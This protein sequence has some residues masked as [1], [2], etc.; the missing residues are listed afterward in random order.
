MKNTIILY[1]LL[2]ISSCAEK[3]NNVIIK[4]DIPNLPNGVLY[5]YKDISTNIVDSTV[6]KD[7]KF[8]I[9]YNSKT[10]EVSY[11]GIDHIDKKGILRAFYFPTNAKYKNSGYDSQFFLSDSVVLI[12]GDFKD[13]KLAGIA[14]G[15]MKI[16]TTPKI[17]AGYQTNALFHIDGDLFDNINKNTYN[18]IASKIKEYSNSYHLLYKINKNRNSFTA[19]QT[20]NLLNLFSGEITDSEPFEIL[21]DY[22]QKRLNSKLSIPML[23]NNKGIK[24]E[25]LDIKFKKHLVVFWASWCGPCREEI[26]ALKKI[27]TNY[28]DEVEFIS[29]STDVN[30]SSWQKALKKED[31]PWNQFIVSEKSKEYEPIEMFFQLSTSIQYVALVDNNMKVIKSNVGLMTYTEMENFIKN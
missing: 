27:H 8:N 15:N 10:N 24:A 13:F 25:V 3:S 31:M 16:I 7:G 14:T 2:L 12:K 9:N 21:F 18:E 28:K 4:G 19:A 29:I 20:Q 1:L 17:K 22:N 23:T 26:P 5:L 11:L 6:T 30:N